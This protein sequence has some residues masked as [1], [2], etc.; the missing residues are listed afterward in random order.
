LHT[1]ESILDAARQVILQRGLR[2][3]TVAAIAETSGASIGSIY[4]RFVS[5]DDLLACL[6]SSPA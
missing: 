1:E 6:W 3:T 4:H 5:V 2:S